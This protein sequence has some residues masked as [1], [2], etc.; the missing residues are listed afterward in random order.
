MN[1][2]SYTAALAP[3][4]LSAH[5]G[6]W[7]RALLFPWN[8]R[9]LPWQHSLCHLHF[10]LSLAQQQRCGRRGPGT[11]SP[12]RN[13][14]LAG[15]TFSRVTWVCLPVADQHRCTA[16]DSPTRHCRA[17]VPSSSVHAAPVTADRGLQPTPAATL[18]KTFS[19]LLKQ[20]AY[21]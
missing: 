10:R 1:L 16:A 15:W 7:P 20:S 12:T 13:L 9:S 11:L 17:R 19:F 6:Q 5:R 14:V 2:G 21:N 4:L 8:V 18:H 3:R